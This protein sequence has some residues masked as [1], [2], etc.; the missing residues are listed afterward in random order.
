M[1]QSRKKRKPVPHERPYVSKLEL[2]EALEEK[3]TARELQALEKQIRGAVQ[4][5]TERACKLAVEETHT[6]DWSIVLRVLRDR[7][8]WGKVRIGRFWEISLDYLKDI[9]SGLIS[10][11]DMLQTLENEDG[12]KIKWTANVE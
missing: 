7:F 8:G 5:A 3:L 2:R 6:R 12:I 1:A 9:E 11:E 10:T 4:I